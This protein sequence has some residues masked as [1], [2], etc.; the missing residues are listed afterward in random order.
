[1]RRPPVALAA[2]SLLL[3]ASVLGAEPMFLSKQYTRCTSCHYSPTGGGLLTPY[4]RSLSRQELSTTR[5]SYPSVPPPPEGTGEE[6]FLWGV[7]GNRLGPVSLGID[8]RPSILGLDVGGPTSSSRSLLMTADLLAAW[9]GHG[10]T[11]Y[12]E[13]GRKP[14]IGQDN[15]GIY[16]Y[17]HWVAY[18][19]PRGLGVRAGRFLPAYGIRLADHT[20]FTRSL[21]GFDKYDQ[22]YALEVSHSGDKHLLQVSVGPG[23]ADAIVHGNPHPFTATGRLQWDLGP[24]TALVFS[25]LYRGGTTLV[26]S[27]HAGGVAFGIAPTKRLSIWTE[28]DVQFQQGSPGSPAYSLLNETGIEVFRGLWLKI[29]PQLRTDYGNT[30]AGVFRWVVEADMLPRTHWNVDVSY[31]H[32][33]TRGTGLVYETLLAQLHLYL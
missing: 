24:R 14:P 19:S 30:S 25:G 31:Y 13:V 11:A 5:R 26:P 33:K 9:H 8:L 6:S 23:S 15:A 7:L 21:L 27:N 18:Q 20:A 22:V 10:F 32:D 16:S 2:L 29:S 28:A 4:G 1:V 17:E 3:G 12:A